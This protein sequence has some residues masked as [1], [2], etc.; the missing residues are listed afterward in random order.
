MAYAQT[1][2]P[3]FETKPISSATTPF[4]IQTE[5]LSY[6][7]SFPISKPLHVAP[8]TATA[9]TFPF[10]QDLSLTDASPPTNSTTHKPKHVYSRLKSPTHKT[11]IVLS[12]E[13]PLSKNPKNPLRPSF[14]LTSSTNSTFPQDAT[15]PTCPPPGGSSSS[16]PSS[17]PP[18]S[19]SS[20]SPR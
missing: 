4:Q 18:F 16:P 8:L 14:S 9:T 15:S 11:P 2:A 10:R 17:S 7:A 3:A 20:G 13:T 19:R 12:L 1:N 5:L 6:N